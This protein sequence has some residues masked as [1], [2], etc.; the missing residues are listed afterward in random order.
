MRIPLNLSLFDNWQLCNVHKLGC[1]DIPLETKLMVSFDE[2]Y[3]L[4][5]VELRSPDVNPLSVME[6]NFPLGKL[7][8]LF[9]KNSTKESGKEND[10]INK[11]LLRA[12]RYFSWQH[13]QLKM[14]CHEIL[15]Y[16]PNANDLD[17]EEYIKKALFVVEFL[18]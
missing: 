3:K 17:V 16:E 1:K 12:A 5:G 18:S 11:N 9:L 6:N 10:S 14:I 4:F 2:L 8:F 7:F 15:I 13:P